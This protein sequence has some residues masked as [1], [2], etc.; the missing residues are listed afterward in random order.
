MNS[1]ARPSKSPI[2]TASELR[3]FCAT[4]EE[5]LMMAI[6]GGRTERRRIQ[7]ELDLRSALGEGPRRPRLAIPRGF[8]GRAAGGAPARGPGTPPCLSAS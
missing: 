7:R 2:M 3:L 8:Q 5:L 4:G 1:A 6:A